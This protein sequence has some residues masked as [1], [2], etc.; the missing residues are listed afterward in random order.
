VSNRPFNF[1]ELRRQ[2]VNACRRKELRTTEFSEETPT[3]WQPNSVVSPL[4]GLSFT[5]SSA[6]DFVADLLEC[7]TPMV[8]VD[9]DKPAGKKGYEMVV[10][11]SKTSS[12]YIKLMS[13]KGGGVHGRSFHPD[14]AR[15]RSG[16]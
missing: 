14:Y 8:E 15:K 11:L 4:S 9:L 13:H 7:G 2:F 6:W 3:E 1:P 16:A 5:E 12:L 10:Q